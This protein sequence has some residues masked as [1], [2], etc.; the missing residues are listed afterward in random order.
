MAGA[1]KS[2][3]RAPAGEELYMARHVSAGAPLKPSQRRIRLQPMATKVARQYKFGDRVR[4]KHY[5]GTFYRIDPEYREFCYIMVGDRT[6]RG[7]GQRV[8]VTCRAWSYYHSRVL[9]LML[10]TDPLSV[11]ILK[12]QKNSKTSGKTMTR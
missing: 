7:A 9:N 2:R 1:R 8:E 10:L 3:N 4:W 5:T 12:Q 6:Y 11:A